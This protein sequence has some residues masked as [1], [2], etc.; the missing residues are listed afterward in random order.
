M[1]LD[2][3]IMMELDLTTT[4]ND[5][6]NDVIKIILRMVIVSLNVRSYFCVNKRFEYILNCMSKKCKLAD[7]E[8]C[9]ICYQKQNIFGQP[10]IYETQ[11]LFDN[12]C[13]TCFL[14]STKGNCVHCNIDFMKDLYNP[15][16]CINCHETNKFFVLYKASEYPHVQY[17]GIK[18]RYCNCGLIG[19]TFCDIDYTV[20][21]ECY[22]KI[23][24]SKLI[25]SPKGFP[26]V[27]NP[28]CPKKL[29]L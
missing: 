22:D 10:K 23:E 6:P 21:I 28:Y 4:I 26:Y 12:V 1:E 5:V 16:I 11:I 17:S 19:A 18:C 20:C 27:I 7:I 13:N 14:H 24:P 25:V 8:H 3:N 9:I 29:K 2:T 15:N